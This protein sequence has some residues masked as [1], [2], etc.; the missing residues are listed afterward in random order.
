MEY[1][2]RKPL[3]LRTVAWFSTGAVLFAGGLASLC[4][5]WFGNETSLASLL[6]GILTGLVGAY[7]LNRYSQRKFQ[8]GG[9]RIR[10]KKR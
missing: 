3:L 6:A 9:G 10:R 1:M 2:E 8:D 4:E 5:G 7:Y